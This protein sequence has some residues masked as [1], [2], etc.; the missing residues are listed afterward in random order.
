MTKSSGNERKRRGAASTRS[1]KASGWR[2][3]RAHHL[4]LT[5]GRLKKLCD[6]LREGVPVEVAASLLGMG[7]DTPRRWASKGARYLDQ[8][9]PEEDSIYARGLISRLRKLV[10][11]SSPRWSGAPSIR[12]L[13][14]GPA[15]S[16]WRSFDAV[17]GTTGRS[18]RRVWR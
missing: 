5:P 6:S 17:T 3:Y 8:G 13:H 2:G 16:R 9:G 7:K 1:G 18:R 4:S 15:A 14:R 12:E 10:P 11:S